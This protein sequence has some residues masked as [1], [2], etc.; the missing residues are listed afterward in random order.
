LA[1]ATVEYS[2]PNIP[3]SDAWVSEDDFDSLANGYCHQQLQYRVAATTDANALRPTADGSE[4][5]HPDAKASLDYYAE[6]RPYLYY[7]LTTAM[8]C[9]DPERMPRNSDDQKWAADM[10]T[11]WG[12]HWIRV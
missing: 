6:N 10:V 5:E 3:G 2:H 9:V 7:D 8:A 4:L 1:N 11:R 12:L